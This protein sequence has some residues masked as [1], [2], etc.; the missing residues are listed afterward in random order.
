MPSYAKFLKEILS[1][2]RRLEEHETVALFEECSAVIRISFPLS[3]NLFYMNFYSSFDL[4]LSLWN[5]FLTINNAYF[6]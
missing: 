2:R 5:T 6:V 3:D 4:L 1:N